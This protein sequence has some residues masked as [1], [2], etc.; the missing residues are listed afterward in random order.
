MARRQGARTGSDEAALEGLP[1]YL[2]I[3]V[4]VAGI[5]IAVIVG[6]FGGV[7]NN[8]QKVIS[9]AEF[10]GADNATIISSITA[11][12]QPIPVNIKVKDPCGTYLSSWSADVKGA[13]WSEGRATTTDLLSLNIK[14]TLA[15]GQNTDTI[16]IVLKK[17]GYVDLSSSLIVL[18]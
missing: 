1:L 11:G 18:R 3:L 14:P 6:F 7:S 8:C 13:G 10:R 5:G 16:N 15:S 9:E 17:G 2:L 4:V 12:S